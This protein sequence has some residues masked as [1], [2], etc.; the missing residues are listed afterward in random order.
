MIVKTPGGHA[1]ETLSIASEKA[2]P[3]KTPLMMHVFGV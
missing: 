2:D 3:V 1:T